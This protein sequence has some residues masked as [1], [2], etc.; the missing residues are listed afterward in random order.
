MIRDNSAH[1]DLTKLAQRDSELIRNTLKDVV[2]VTF[3][4]LLAKTEALIN[5]LEGNHDL[6]ENNYDPD[7]NQESLAA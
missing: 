2:V 7:S 1:V 6:N 4:E 5:A 3:D